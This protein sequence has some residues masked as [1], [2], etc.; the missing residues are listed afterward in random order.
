MK[1]ESKKVVGTNKQQKGHL[2]K[3]M[4]DGSFLLAMLSFKKRMLPILGVKKERRKIYGIDK[5]NT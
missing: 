5:E 3:S 1:L 2:P 4:A